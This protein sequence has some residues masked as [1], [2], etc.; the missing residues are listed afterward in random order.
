MLYEAQG[1]EK[2]KSASELHIIPVGLIL[3]YFFFVWFHFNVTL[4]FTW[5]F[6]FIG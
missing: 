2:W 1:S 3:R 5:L 4:K 6:E